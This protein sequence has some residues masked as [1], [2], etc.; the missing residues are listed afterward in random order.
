[1]SAINP[2]IYKHML[3][4]YIVV[5]QEICSTWNTIFQVC[6]NICRRPAMK[7]FSPSWADICIYCFAFV[8]EGE[9]YMH[10]THIRLIREKMRKIMIVYRIGV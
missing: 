8:S 5:P 9:P 6:S 4:I 10:K 2:L 3:H 7:L 1:M